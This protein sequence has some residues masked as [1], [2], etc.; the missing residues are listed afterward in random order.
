MTD[1][2]SFCALIAG[3]SVFPTAAH[4][5]PAP[6]KLATGYK[7]ESFHGKNLTQ[8]AREVTAQPGALRIDLAADN[9][10]FKLNEIFDAVR[11][12]KVQMG[13]TIMTSLTKEMPVTGADSVPFVVR[14]YGDA[15]RMW[16]YQRPLIEKRFLMAGVRCLMAVPW[17]PQ[18]L[19]TNKPINR[20]SDLRG[21]KMRTYNVTTQR[22]ADLLGA[23]PVDVP[24][25]QVRQA[26]SEGRIDCMIT[27]AVTGVDNQV[28][29]L[30]KNY[31]EIN[32][33]FPKNVTFVNAQAFDAL[34]A[35][36]Q[37]NLL[38]AA[39]AAEARGWAESEKAA[40]ESVE[41]L[42][43]HGMK[44]ERVPAEFLVELKRLGERFSL[45]WIKQVGLEA[46]EIF[47]PYFTKQ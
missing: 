9:S 2:R 30:V 16:R 24:M 5:Q 27:S 14:S 23:T 35:E 36:S 13:E 15:L 21:A 11:T 46:N 44:I 47:I 8:F 31:Y 45:E 38:K 17:P 3:A 19:Y 25:L 39:A 32:A 26:L 43:R 6:W 12:G 28:W 10:L 37:S 4:A 1:R 42:R 22:I 33:W 34:P 40:A 29:G 18:G 20:A 41:E 7:A